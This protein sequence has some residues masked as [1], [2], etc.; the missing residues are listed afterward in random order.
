MGLI[1][2]IV[3]AAG[4]WLMPWFT[5]AADP[6]AAEVAG[7]GYVLLWIAAGYQF[8]DGFNIASGACLRGAGDVRVPSFMVLAL[9]WALF[10]PLAHALS[11]QSGDGWVRLAAAVRAWSGRRMVRRAGLCMLLG[12]DVVSALEIGSVAKRGVAMMEHAVHR[13]LACCAAGLLAASAASASTG[14]IPAPVAHALA[15][16][17]LAPTSASFA[18]LDMDSGRMV[19]S[20][21]AETLRSPASTMKL[22]TTFAGLDLLGPAYT[23][24]TDALMRGPLE[25]G[26]L[27]GDLILKG[28]GDPYMTLERWWSFVHALRAKGIRT[29][30]GDIVVDDTAFALPP[31]DPG[32]FDG[33]P[34]R[35]YNVEPDA[36]MVN[37]QSVEFR[38]AAE[39]RHAQRSTS[40][41]RRRRSISPSI[42]GSLS[43]RDAAAEP[44]PGWTS[45]CPRRNRIACILR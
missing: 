41:R 38:M 25:E 34:N 9:S 24:H 5:N 8:F 35:S 33:R 17:R 2:V 14:V 29:I 23:W 13:L 31:E 15:T 44:R 43:W 27:R 22:V 32:A 1:G 7:K 12:N 16:G 42:T 39:C 28:G 36:L 11:F 4:R 18:V 30:G 10:V 40:S 37:F 45:R 20:L 3:A 26:V 21:N 6:Q 19:A